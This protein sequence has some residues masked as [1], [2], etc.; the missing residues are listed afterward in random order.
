MKNSINEGLDPNNPSHIIVIE[1]NNRNQEIYGKYHSKCDLFKSFC[2]C[3]KENLNN[4]Q[5]R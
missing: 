2:H 5:S 3:E 1:I 4:E